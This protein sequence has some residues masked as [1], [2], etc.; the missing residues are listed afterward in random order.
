MA[1]KVLGLL[2]AGRIAFFVLLHDI[3][4][5][6][7]LHGVIESAEASFEALLLYGHCQITTKL[8]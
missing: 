8:S 5:P 3:S 6:G 4:W 7:G 1:D 2:G